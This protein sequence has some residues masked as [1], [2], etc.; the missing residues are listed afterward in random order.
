MG[1]KEWEKSK[2]KQF[3]SYE[4]QHDFAIFS[5]VLSHLILK[6]PC[7]GCHYYLHSIDKGQEGPEKLA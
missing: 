1:E 2:H 4:S 3:I 6:E 5:N 7:E